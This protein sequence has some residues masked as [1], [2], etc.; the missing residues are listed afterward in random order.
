MK[1]INILVYDSPTTYHNEEVDESVF[2]KDKTLEQAI[3]EKLAEITDYDNS[4]AVNGFTYQGNELWFTAEVRASFK[5]SI[6]SASLLGETEISIP[7][8]AGIIKLSLDNAKLML[9]KIQRY[10]DACYL[11][12][13]QHKEEV[14]ML[15][16]VAEVEAYDITNG[17]P[18][19]LAF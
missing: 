11:V 5:N 4:K 14:E 12:T 7:T 19:K 9:A 6:E 1:K 18:E 13:M 17:Y 15:T 10:A 2:M 3:N 8:S 16:T